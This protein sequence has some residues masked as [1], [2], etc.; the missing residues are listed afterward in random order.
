MKKRI[1]IIAGLIIIIGIVLIVSNSQLKSS[2]FENVEI[3]EDEVIETMEEETEEEQ[4]QSQESE[5]ESEKQETGESRQISKIL[6]DVVRGTIDFFSNRETHVVAIGDSLTKGVGDS[7][8]QG[9]YVGILDRSINQETELVLFDN[10]GIRGYRSD[11]L[12]KY[13]DEPEVTKSITDSD[14]VLITIGANDIMQVVKKNFTDLN[15]D[16][17][18]QERD[19]YEERLRQ[20]FTKIQ[21]MNASTEIYL[22]G[23]YNPFE[24][25]FQ[26]I[27]ELSIIVEEWNSTGKTIAEEY[28]NV[29]FIPTVDLFDDPN[30]DLFAEDN[31]HP[32]DLG[33]QRMARRVLEYL[34][35]E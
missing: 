29:T 16:D 33:Y 8:K 4:E 22:L 25:Y 23:F 13:L 12:L 31:F 5:E 14:I 35:D 20:I 26:E 10:Y 1:F 6:L 2:T 32:N 17:F 24:K 27:E 18:M 7:K 28:N 3:P 30:A 11:Q 9:G 21:D 34:T 19:R 15:L